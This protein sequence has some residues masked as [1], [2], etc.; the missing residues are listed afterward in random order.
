MIMRLQLRIKNA[1]VSKNTYNI[2]RHQDKQLLTTGII[3]RNSQ[4]IIFESKPTLERHGITT[5][6]KTRLK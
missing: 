4:V 6:V 5:S 2:H 3:F 1:I